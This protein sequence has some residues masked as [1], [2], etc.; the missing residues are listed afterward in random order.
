MVRV[1]ENRCRCATAPDFFQ[2]F[3]VRH[4]REAASAVFLRRSHAE[5]TDAAQTV[6]HLARNVCLAIDLRR[7]EMLIENLAEFPERFIQLDLSRR[8]SYI[9]GWCRIRCKHRMR[10]RG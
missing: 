1:Y 3:A 9:P 6:D 10:R 7:I 4:L 8:L 5:H 2:H